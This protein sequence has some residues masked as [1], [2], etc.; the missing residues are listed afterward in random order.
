MVEKTILIVDDEEHVSELLGLYLQREGFAVQVADDGLDG[1][2]KA[3]ELKPDLI[4]L[5]IMLPYKD[6]W[7]VAREL[8]QDGSTVPIIMLS[9]KSEECDK[10]LGLDLGGDDYVTKPFAPGEVV[11][12]V[13]AILRRTRTEGQESSVLEFPCLTIDFSRYEI[14]ING[15]KVVCTPKEIELLWLLAINRG[16]VFTREHLLDKVWGYDYLGDSRTVD[17]HVKR[18]RKKIE[19]DHPYAYLHTVWGVGYKFEVMKNN[20]KSIQ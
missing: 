15:K 10:I 7:Q 11:A 16:L 14:K 6:G 18:L 1:L 5:D 4:I 2:H 8:R 12:R 19:K 9:A 20:E 3:R 13:K 17:T